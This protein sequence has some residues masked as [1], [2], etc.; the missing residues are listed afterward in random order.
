VW[1]RY[2]YLWISV[3]SWLF[4]YVIAVSM[5][6]YAP[7]PPYESTSHSMGYEHAPS[8]G[9]SKG[10]SIGV[11][12]RQRVQQRLRILQVG[13]VKA[14]GEPVIDWCQ[15]VIGFLAFPLLLPEPSQA[16]SRS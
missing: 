2:L 15:Q 11:V 5:H 14:L 12:L 4:P 16:A 3:V 6:V 8:I 7:P 13:G 10:V 1:S 9:G